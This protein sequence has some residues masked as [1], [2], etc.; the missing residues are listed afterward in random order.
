MKCYQNQENEFLQHVQ[1]I[2][3]LERHLPQYSTCYLI[4]K[5]PLSSMIQAKC[6]GFFFHHQMVMYSE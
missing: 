5:Y 3:L 4:K 1:I 2:E 6:G